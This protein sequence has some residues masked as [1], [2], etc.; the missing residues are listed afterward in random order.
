MNGG[1]HGLVDTDEIFEDF[2]DRG[3]TV[4]SARCVGENLVVCGNFVFV[5]A[6]DDSLGAFALSW[7][8]DNDFFGASFDVCAGIFWLS[9][10]ASTFDDDIDT[11][12]APWEILW[13]FFAVNANLLAFDDDVFV[14]GI[15]ITGIN[16][17]A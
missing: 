17:V 1:H 3:N 15:N 12:F 16:A 9:K 13:I 5:D 4:R 8:R 14:V 6:E 2:H 11:E 7:G 10:E